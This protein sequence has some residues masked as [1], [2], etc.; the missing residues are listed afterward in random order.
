M[1]PQVIAP[2]V[3]DLLGKLHVQ[4]QSPRKISIDCAIVAVASIAT[5]VGAEF[6]SFY[7]LFMPFLKQ[8]VSSAPAQMGMIRAKAI[9]CISLIAI[10]VGKEQFAA[11]ANEVMEHMASTAVAP[12]DPQAEY[13]TKAWPRLCQCLGQ[14]FVPYLEHVVPGLLAS[15]QKKCDITFTDVDEVPYGLQPQSLWIAPAASCKLTRVRSGRARTTSTKI[16][17]SATRCWASGRP[18]WRRR[19]TPV[20]PW[21]GSSR[22]CRRGSTR[23][24]SRASP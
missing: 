20:A 22:R 8:I 11:D 14:D 12:D 4:M 19:T 23:T 18:T 9:E 3:Q 13:I 6:A 17:R 16:C 1:C 21:P 10:A 5:I 15:A 7:D 2:F 24:S